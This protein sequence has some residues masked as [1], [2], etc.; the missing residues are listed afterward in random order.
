MNQAYLFEI[1]F[2][3]NTCCV[4]AYLYLIIYKK[5]DTYFVFRSASFRTWNWIFPSVIVLNLRLMD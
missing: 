1:Y 4:L 2:E 3:H 5:E